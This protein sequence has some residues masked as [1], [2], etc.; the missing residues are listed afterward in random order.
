MKRS[1][2]EK[3]IL[4]SEFYYNSADPSVRTDKLPQEE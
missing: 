3:T 2:I 1:D 4:A